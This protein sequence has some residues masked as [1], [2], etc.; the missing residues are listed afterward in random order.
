MNYHLHCCCYCLSF[1][2]NPKTIKNN[3]KRPVV[4]RFVTMVSRSSGGSPVCNGV[5]NKKKRYWPHCRLKFYT[6]FYGMWT[7]VSPLTL[8]T[9]TS[10]VAM[11]GPAAIITSVIFQFW[12]KLT[13]KP[14]AK[15]EALWT[16]YAISPPK[17]PL[18]AFTSLTCTSSR[19]LL[20]ARSRKEW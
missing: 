9:H 12:M 11:T 2:K 17:P 8:C 19:P 13:T 14:E 6:G 20:V 16:K 18:S 5:R 1:W 10:T 7:I 4:S 3:L 15:F